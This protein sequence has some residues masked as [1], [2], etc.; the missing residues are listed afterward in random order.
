VKAAFEITKGDRPVM[1]LSESDVRRCLDLDELIEALQDGFAAL[2]RGEVQSPPRPQVTVPGTGFSLAMMA[3]RP[4]GPIAVKVVNV[5]DGNLEQGLPNHLATINLY[6]P[7]TGAAVC[8]MDGTYITGIRTAATAA[9]SA[10]LLARAD[11]TVATIVGAGVQGREHLRVLPLVR[12]LERIHVCSLRSE[13][14][15]RLARQSPLASATTDLQAA[16]RASD[17][18]CLATHSATP[19]IDAAWVRP[20]THVTS[21]GYH[22]PAGEL[23]LE[24]A[25]R[26]RVFVETEDAFAPP[27]VGCGELAGLDPSQGTTL[28]A[29]ALGRTQGRITDDEITIYKGMGL[30]MEDMVAAHLAYRRAARDGVGGTMEW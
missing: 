16:V 5:F 6:D 10:R 19:V 20:G 25:R 12:G 2:E 26:H 23:P 1:T 15:E 24:L 11:A 22:P 29:V 18:V 17:I 27:P 7:G 9:L 21:V 30:A 4:A 13:D 28:G 14:A 8:V 3:W